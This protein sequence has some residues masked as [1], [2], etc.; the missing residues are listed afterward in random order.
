MRAEPDWSRISV[1][2]TSGSGKTT[3][4]RRLAAILNVPN[5]E[6]DA[7][8]WGPCW[9]PRPLEQFRAD[10]GA[11]VAK[12]RWVVDGN[13]AVV[14]PLVW[15]RP[16]AIVWLDLPFPSN[17]RQCEDLVARVAAHARAPERIREPEAAF[18]V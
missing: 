2:G 9:T 10:V 1:V 13:Y 8:H 11:A 4:A 6:L 14:R 15:A 18:E 3:L 7:L 17:D 16:T 12:D 5:I